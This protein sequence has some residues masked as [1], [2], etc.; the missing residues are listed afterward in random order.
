MTL[1]AAKTG[2]SVPRDEDQRVFLR[3]LTW[4]EYEVLLAVKGERAGV[5]MAYL[6]GDVELMT[7]RKEAPDLAI[8]VVWT[9]G[10]IEKLEIYRG[11]GVG[12]V[13]IWKDGALAVFVLVGA[14][15]QRVERSRLLPEL[16]LALLSSF[17]DHD[18]QTQAVR[19]F[20][21]ALR[22]G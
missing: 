4:S 16:D 5:R 7:E 14:A 18:G 19:A 6:E 13:W 15:Y 8:E 21:A 9:H 20:R 12:E 2:S 11:L 1:A 22:Q 10:G 17:L 3:G